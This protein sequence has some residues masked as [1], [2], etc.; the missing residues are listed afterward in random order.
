MRFLQSALTSI[1]L[2]LVASVAATWLLRRILA[3]T[4][5]GE[6]HPSTGDNSPSVVVVPVI[7]IGNTI[8][9]PTIKP[10]LGRKGP[11]HH[12]KHRRG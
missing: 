3:V 6:G 4:P 1:T 7:V 11:L 9:S 10:P 12:M 8:G 5:P 2:S